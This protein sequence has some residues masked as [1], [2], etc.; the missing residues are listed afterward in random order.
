MRAS[1]LPLVLL[2]FALATG[3]GAA[4]AAPLDTT[5]ATQC[6]TFGFSIDPDP[7]G[8]NLRSAPRVDAPVIG[9]LAPRTRITP[10]EIVGVTF[11]IV[12]SKDGWLLIKNGNPEKDFML[13]AANAADGRGW[14]S[15][16]LVG[17]TLGAAALRTAPRRDAS[18]VANLSGPGRSPE[19]TAVSVVHGCQGK[20]V[21]VTAK[22]LDGKPARGWSWA[23][24]FLQLTPCDRGGMTE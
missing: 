20:Y 23:P 19:S 3:Q 17:T 13:D 16:K 15:G 11:E 7:K 14:V 9:R 18:P 5:G 10:D 21:E 8:T 2:G 22:P 12:G 24:C 6:E 1:R 4:Q